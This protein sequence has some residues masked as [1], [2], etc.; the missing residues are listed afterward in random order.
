M[1]AKTENDA[2]GSPAVEP[3]R[4]QAILEF[5]QEAARLKDTLRNTRTAEG[6][7]ESTAEHTWRLCLMVMLFSAELPGIDMLRLLKICIVHD[8]GEAISG[9]TPA[10]AQHAGDGRADRERDD[11]VTLCG[12]LPADL[13]REILDLWDEY[14]QAKTPEAILAKGFDKL[15]TIFQHAIGANEDDFDYVFNL[16]YGAEQTARHPLLK[17]I[18]ALADTVT[19]D[20]ANAAG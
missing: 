6:R 9:D 2:A 11:L 5:L 13:E 7:Q 15:E 16:G 20:R 10:V 17:Q 19:A 3:L 18:R 14:K 8:L 1:S 4:L 12:P